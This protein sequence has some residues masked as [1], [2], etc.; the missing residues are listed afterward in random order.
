[1]FRRFDTV[2]HEAY[3]AV[4]RYIDDAYM[5]HVP[6]DVCPINWGLAERTAHAAL[7]E[8][9]GHEVVQKCIDCYKRK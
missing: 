7:D 8:I 1:M 4:Q 3:K 5:P 9:F 2:P 6:I